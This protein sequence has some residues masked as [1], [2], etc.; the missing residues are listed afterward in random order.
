MSRQLVTVLTKQVHALETDLRRLQDALRET[1]TANVVLFT[2][3]RDMS[4][5]AVTNN[6]QEGIELF[7]RLNEKFRANERVLHSRGVGFAIIEDVPV[8]HIHDTPFT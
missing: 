6:T 4:V 5:A 1:K 2:T 3:N 8:N 7:S